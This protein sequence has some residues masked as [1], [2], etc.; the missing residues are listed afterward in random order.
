MKDA[1]E[2]GYSGQDTAKR[3]LPKQAWKWK[4]ATAFAEQQEVKYIWI[5]QREEEWG[6]RLG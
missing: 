6:M 2:F 5:G 4:E 3:G 1:Q